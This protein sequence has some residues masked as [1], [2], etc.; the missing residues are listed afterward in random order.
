MV[1]TK[2]WE[3]ITLWMWVN[4]GL[5]V[6][7]FGGVFDTI[8]QQSSLEEGWEEDTEQVGKIGRNAE[9]RRKKSRSKAT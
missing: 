7:W 1:V 3:D 5:L 9:E 2:P 6:I 8:D 4:V